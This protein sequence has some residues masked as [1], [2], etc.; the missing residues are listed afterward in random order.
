MRPSRIFMLLYKKERYDGS[1]QWPTPLPKPSIEPWLDGPPVPLRVLEKIK[2]KAK[3]Q[4]K[5]L[6]EALLKLH[7]QGG[8]NPLG[9]PHLVVF[10]MSSVT[11]ALDCCPCMLKQSKPI[12][13]LNR[14][15]LLHIKERMRLMGFN[16]DRFQEPVPA[17]LLGNSMAINVVERLL[18]RILPAVRLTG[19]LPDRWQDGSAQKE[20]TSTSVRG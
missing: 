7:K 11:T 5:S 13:V 14:G 9:E 4:A 8:N 10:G 12:W 15:R 16:P 3:G 17:A 2:P 20:L 6:E 19:R 1:F 18:C